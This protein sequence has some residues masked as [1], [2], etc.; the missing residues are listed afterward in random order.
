MTN[1]DRSLLVHTLTQYDIKQ[2]TKKFYNRYALGIYMGTVQTIADL[3]DD[4]VT[5]SDAINQTYSD[6]LRDYVRKNLGL[7][8]LTDDE[9]ETIDRQTF[10]NYFK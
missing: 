9:I 8:K 2:S 1:F 6:R 10:N 5:L 7:S 4:G 3:L